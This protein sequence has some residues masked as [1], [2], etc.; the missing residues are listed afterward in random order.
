MKNLINNSI[1]KIRFAAFSIICLLVIAVTALSQSNY[2]AT[3]IGGATPAGLA[4]GKALGSYLVNDIET[5]NLFNGNV[6][7]S[8]PLISIGGRGNAGYTMYKPVETP[9]WVASSNLTWQSC[10]E[11]DM[12]GYWSSGIYA[13]PMYLRTIKSDY[14]AGFVEVRRVGTN[15]NDD[16][17]YN[18][19][20]RT[21]TTITFTSADGTGHTLYDEKYGGNGLDWTESADLN[22]E[23]IFRAKDGSALV[24]I[25]DEDVFDWSTMSSSANGIS[26]Y[27]KT[28]SGITYRINTFGKV[29]WIRDADGN[30]S[31]FTY[32]TTPGIRLSK[33]TDSAGREVYIFY[34]VQNEYG[35]HDQIVYKG[36]NGTSRTV[37]VVKSTIGNRFLPSSG[38]T[39][40]ANIF[41]QMS[42]STGSSSHAPLSYGIVSKIVIPDGRTYEFYYNEYG[43]VSRLETPAGA[44][45]EYGFGAGEGAPSPSYPSGQV[46]NPIYNLDPNMPAPVIYVYRRLKERR[47]YTNGGSSVTRKTTYVSDALGEFDVAVSDFDPI[48]Q[49][50]LAKTV[51]Y[52]HGS[53]M[54]SLRMTSPQDSVP[55]YPLEGREF[56]TE[57]L[58]IL[59]NSVLAR[60]DNE[61]IIGCWDTQVFCTGDTLPTASYVRSTER[62]LTGSVSSVS[63]STF[64]YDKYNNVTDTFEYDFGDDYAG[65]LVRRSHTDYIT[66]GNYTNPEGRN[67]TGLPSQSWTSSDLSGTN[68]VTLSQY[69]YDVYTTNNTHA[70]LVSRSSVTGHDTINYGIAN[71]IRGNLTK[72][73]SYANA[74]SSSGAITA[75][76]QYDILGN[77]VK[78][79]DANGNS[80]TVSFSDNFGAPDGEATTNSAPSQLNGLETYAFV[81]SVTNALGW[82]IYLQYDYYTGAP[83]NTKDI[84]GIISKTIYDDVLDRPTQTVS[85]INALARQTTIDYDDANH[86][87][88]VTTDF[89]SFSDNRVKTVSFYDGAGRTTES[90]SYE[91]NGNFKAIKTQYDALGRA[92]KFSN[93]FRPT[94]V[95]G[96]H[97]IL[98]TERRFDSLGRIYEIETPDG[99]K[100]LSSYDRNRVLVADQS[101]KKRISKTNGLGQLTD[102]WEITASDTATVPVTFPGANGTGVS[103]GYQTHYTYDTVG[104]LITVNQGNQTRSFQ[105]DSLSRLTSATNPELGT[106]PT[107]GT[108]NYTYDTNGNLKTKRDVRN[109]K[110]IYDY[111][112]LNRVTKRCYR[113]IGTGSLGMTTCVNNPET[114][115]VNTNDVDYTYE[116]TSVTDLKGVL[117]KV[118]NVFSTTE[119]T[120][121]D[122]EGRIK[123]SRQT[124]AGIA[125]NEQLYSYN[126]AGALTEQT[127]PS[128]RSVKNI[129]DDA[130]SLSIVQSKKNASSGY[131]NY[132]DAF[133]YNAAGAVTKLQIGNGHWYSTQFNNRLQPTQIS[134]GKTSGATDLMNLSYAYGKWEGESLN[135]S[136]NNG[137]IAQQ[138]ITV[139]TV[140][141]NPGFAATQKYEYD[142]LN[143]LKDAAEKIS[144]NQTWKQSFI[145]DQ[146]GNRNFDENST[147]T[148]TKSCGTSPN[149]TV[150]PAD[151]KVENPSIS[152]S[153]NRLIQDQNGDTI[154]D[155]VMDPSGNVTR[156]ARG[157]SFVYDGE[158]HQVEV[159]NSRNQPIGNY[160]Y[161]GDG[162]R[163]KKYVPGT[164]EITLFAYDATGRLVAEYSTQLSPTPQVAYTTMDTLGSPRINT[165]QNGA[166]LARHDYRPFGEEIFTSQRGP[167][168]GYGADDV[169]KKF[170]GYEKDIETGLNF[171]QARY[172][173]ETQ[174]RFTSPDPVMASASKSNPQTFNRYS[175]VIN[176]PLNMTDPSGLCPPE[177][178]KPCNVGDIMEGKYDTGE[179]YKMVWNGEAWTSVKPE[180]SIEMGSTSAECPDCVSSD[181]SGPIPGGAPGTA[182]QAQPQVEPAERKKASSAS[183]NF[184]RKVLNSVKGGPGTSAAALL[185]QEL[186]YPSQAVGND[187]CDAVP[188]ACKPKDTTEIRDD[189]T[190]V[191][192]GESDM[193]S[194]GAAFS[195]AFGTSIYQASQGVPHGQVR[196]TTAGQIRDGGGVVIYAPEECY[197]GGPINYQHVNIVMGPLGGGFQGPIPNPVPKKLRVPGRAP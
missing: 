8:I 17:H 71:T 105:Y 36:F 187:T 141:S 48:T 192:G 51:H 148:L 25:A 175:Y 161:D 75:Y 91:A 158:N 151:R 162:K 94:E 45:V 49:D 188:D 189:T 43:E 165:D 83:V 122:S 120:Q 7:I 16:P 98:W 82:T 106:T 97:P 112:A 114:P 181:L 111:D 76:S 190:I 169:R 123:K 102:V 125:F 85:A 77:L 110:T 14:E 28:G 6:S 84:N 30:L 152:G 2:T 92:Y 149:F 34:G 168:Y 191:R 87:V 40:G 144:G 47:E 174:G 78:T 124:T 167:Q 15:Y 46:G 37:R 176:N 101:G 185:I 58:N 136:M 150:C 69:E 135:S 80:S 121:F 72:V 104:N 21:H 62:R 157:M 183:K 172:Q 42:A 13:N 38:Y 142:S 159:K 155:Y 154:D 145:Y 128:G 52:F 113:S 31:T 35:L 193:P 73:T 138:V 39:T 146:Y 29:E 119:Y 23:R 90:R 95:D 182:P 64:S 194:P 173:D 32:D 186:A 140:G 66:D 109:I 133:A 153:S 79:I 131:W 147:T 9:Q 81:K 67:M 170:T 139:P 65:A 117:T 127:Y 27:L 184:A 54:Y 163:V 177:D 20:M 24:F 137:N 3:S 56:K 74:P 103:H 18:M 96:S 116:N 68:K 108:I 26:G 50:L 41:P 55:E 126:L 100:V 4:T 143:R 195:G 86:Q 99:A 115:E 132:A 107:N 118:T 11:D 129:L 53:P 166:V 156:N 197:P 171:A 164:G 63:K 19:F 61:W 179:A 12:C 130:G 93:P 160:F 60:V 70:P 10:G 196:Y 57:I 88:Q 44:A 89:N 33:V 59:D 22:R 134:L 180:K 1:K 178:D 5:V